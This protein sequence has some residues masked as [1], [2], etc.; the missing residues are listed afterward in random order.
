VDPETIQ[1]IAIIAGGR[2]LLAL[3]VHVGSTRLIDNLLAE[4]R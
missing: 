1:P 3:A 4:E 2:V